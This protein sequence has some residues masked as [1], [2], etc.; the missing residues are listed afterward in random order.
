[1]RMFRR[2]RGRG[3]GENTMNLIFMSI[4]CNTKLSY[5]L[6][7]Y[8]CFSVC[9]LEFISFPDSCWVKMKYKFLSRSMTLMF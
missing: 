2:K 6:E 5:L 1:M 9:Q 4:N 8:I 3:T 7:S